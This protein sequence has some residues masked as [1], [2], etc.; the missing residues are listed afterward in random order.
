[1]QSKNSRFDKRGSDQSAAG[2]SAKMSKALA[3]QD[4]EVESG[5]LL[6]SG[7][8]SVEYNFKIPLMK[9]RL[10]NEGVWKFID[11][12][13]EPGL[14]AAAGVINEN[15]FNDLVGIDVDGA[16]TARIVALNLEAN[17][18][19]DEQVAAI[20]PPH[21]PPPGGGAA[22]TPQQ[23][24]QRTAEINAQRSI[25]LLN[26]NMKTDDIRQQLYEREEVRQFKHKKFK[27]KQQTL[28]KEILSMFSSELL[29][30]HMDDLN[31]KLFRKVWRGIARTFDGTAGGVD[32]SVTLYDEISEFTYCC[33]H[34]FEDNLTYV[35][36]VGRMCNYPD[37]VLLVVL[38]RGIERSNVH[39]EL[40][41]VARLHK[42]LV[43]STYDI[44]CESLR[45]VY[46]KLLNSG[47]LYV[48]PPKS[49][50][51]AAVEMQNALHIQQM[52][53]F[54]Q[55]WGNDNG[56]N[57]GRGCPGGGRGRGR[58]RGRGGRGRGRGDSRGEK[59]GRDDN[60][61]TC[62]H[63]SMTG[64]HADKCYKLHPCTICK[65]SSHGNWNHDNFVKIASERAARAGGGG[66]ST[67]VSRTS[68][69]TEPFQQQHMHGMQ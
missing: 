28:G 59:R 19:F 38:I 7:A 66:G 54:S 26:I 24:A 20:L 56:D 55:V 31:E 9:Q 34:T 8:T 22:W 67:G 35:N 47:K 68:S 29:A 58:G 41:A 39:Y 1:M 5:V 40:K 11:P 33:E 45:A 52:A 37:P 12:A 14:P 61:P 25:A 16:T 36:R 51:T 3:A 30:P 63:C 6:K 27:D 43:T 10:M 44:V 13:Q 64:H 32:N 65:S 17:N 23:V 69:L 42:H 15:V 53:F 46:S 62:S 57:G 48:K 4:E 18:S 50:A 49:T 60:A 21:G 2:Q